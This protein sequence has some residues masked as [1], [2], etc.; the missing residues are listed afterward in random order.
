MFTTSNE[1]ISVKWVSLN[2]LV[3]SSSKYG[4][5]YDRIKVTHEIGLENVL[6]ADE[7]F[8]I[9][10][11]GNPVDTRTIFPDGNIVNFAGQRA[12][13][14]DDEIQKYETAI[15]ERDFEKA[16][17]MHQLLMATKF[18]NSVPFSAGKQV[19][20]FDYELAL[21]PDE[22]GVFDLKMWAPMPSF[23]LVTGGQIT[24]TI[25][26]PSTN[27]NAFNAELIDVKGFSADEQGN[28]QNEIPAAL[29]QEFLIRRLLVWTWQ[30]DPL[31][32]IKYKYI[33]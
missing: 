25:Q 28:L 1:K 9:P 19:L 13:D 24:T 17:K 12:K 3:L 26:M 16:E 14:L 29:N 31:F 6:Q 15:K 5:E 20:T 11:P 23:Q 8:Y 18:L 32:N 22:N 4:E 33:G 30:N 27:N 7:S 2:A 10:A 21:F